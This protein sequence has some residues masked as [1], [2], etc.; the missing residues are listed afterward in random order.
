[1]DFDLGMTELSMKLLFLSL[2]ASVL[3]HDVVSR[4][5]PNRIMLA[6]LA[7]QAGFLLVLGHGL[8]GLQPVQSL[9]G[10]AIGL[11]FFIPLYAFGAMGAGDVK[12]F[13][14]LGL[15]LGPGALLPIWLIGSALA[16][17]HAIVFYLGRDGPL[18]PLLQYAALRVENNA[19]F[20]RLAVRRNGRAG[21][22]YAAYL[23]LGA[24]AVMFHRTA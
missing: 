23:A 20:Q 19:L 4:R 15:L 3:L 21:I 9:F 11:A 24:A 22:P 8:E 10:F 1:L 14:V 16:G 13:A 7:V 12:F 17:V 6:A 5:V 2:C 18:S